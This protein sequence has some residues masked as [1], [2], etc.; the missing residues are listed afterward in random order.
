[1]LRTCG[2]HFAGV[3]KGGFT[4][5]ESSILKLYSSMY[6]QPEPERFPSRNLSLLPP[7]PSHYAE[8]L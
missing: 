3:F 8:F 5:L 1:M 6:L 4:A 7:Y 2:E